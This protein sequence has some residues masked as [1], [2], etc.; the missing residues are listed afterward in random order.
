[1]N[2]PKVELHCHL[3]GAIPPFLF[4]RYSRELQLVPENMS[5]EQWLQQ[6][7]LQESMTLVEALAK[8]DLLLRLL[9]EPDHLTET[10]HALLN[11]MYDRGTR[12]AEIRFSPQSHKATMSMQQAVE[13][14]LK[15]R[16]LALRD[17]PDMLSGIILCMMNIGQQ[18]NKQ[19]NLETVRLAK[20]YQNEGVVAIDLAGSEG[21]VEMDYYT[22]GFQLARELNVNYTIHAGESG[23][24][25]HVQYALDQKATR[26]GHGVHAIFDD[27]VVENLIQEQATLEV[28]VTS[29][30][31]SK[32]CDGYPDHPVRKLFDRGVR[33][34]INTDDPELMGIDLQH[35]YDILKNQFGFTEKELIQTNLYG[36]MASFCPGKEKVVEELTA[37]LKQMEESE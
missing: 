4:C 15:G 17:H 36:A 12:I 5:D 20:K 8:F 3:D 34:N 29:N 18:G 7:H 23:P 11:L 27:Q 13:A 9:A 28:S 6:N 31:L 1:M 35:E 26:I 16:Q 37:I 30:V 24:A 21:L 33:I 14:V 19:D 10:T 25:S 22:D 32:S 2:Y